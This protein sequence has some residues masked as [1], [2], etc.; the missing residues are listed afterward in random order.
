MHKDYTDNMKQKSEHISELEEITLNAIAADRQNRYNEILRHMHTKNTLNREPCERTPTFFSLFSSSGYSVSFFAYRFSIPTL[1]LKTAGFSQ[2][3]LPGV[4]TTVIILLVMVWIALFTIGLV[5][6]G[7]YLWSRR[8]QTV[9][10]NGN[11]N[12]EDQNFELDEL[13]KMPLRVVAIPGDETRV[14]SLI[15]P[16]YEFLD[17]LSSDSDSESS[18]SDEDDYRIF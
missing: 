16:E 7:N 15:Q 4:F 5:E 8:G 12:D 11:G 9:V 13:M 10:G 14:N 2:F 17:A 3:P 18:T 6:L 1:R